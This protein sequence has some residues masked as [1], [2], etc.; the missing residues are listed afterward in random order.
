MIDAISARRRR[1]GVA[2]G[3]RV[4]DWRVGHHHDGTLIQR[5]RHDQPGWECA[6]T[7]RA[8]PCRLKRSLRDR[9]R[10]PPATPDPEFRSTAPWPGRQHGTDQRPSQYSARHHEAGQQIPLS[11]GSTVIPFLAGG[12]ARAHEF[13]SGDYQITAKAGGVAWLALGATDS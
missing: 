11:E 2:P 5:R 9:A 6:A 4:R 13:V 1:S 8:R 7:I 12:A 3:R 10:R